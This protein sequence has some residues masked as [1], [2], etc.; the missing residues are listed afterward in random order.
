MQQQKAYLNDLKEVASA[1]GLYVSEDM[2]LNKREPWWKLLIC[3]LAIV[4]VHPNEHGEYSLAVNDKSSRDD[5]VKVAGAMESKG[6]KMLVR[7]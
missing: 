6:Y 1:L 5:V 7:I 3:P 2:E 4:S